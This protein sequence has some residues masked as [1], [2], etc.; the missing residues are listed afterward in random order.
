MIMTR[1]LKKIKRVNCISAF[2]ILLLSSC[3]KDT[4]DLDKTKSST[5][6]P[7]IAAPLINTSLRT[8]EVLN[9]LN[10]T[11]LNI[12]PQTGEVTIEY[13]DE[14]FNIGADEL[15]DIPD[16][17]ETVNYTLTVDDAA[18]LQSLDSI[19]LPPLTE[20]INIDVSNGIEINTL[21]LDSGFLN[22]NLSTDLQ[23]RG[24]IQIS[25]PELTDGNGLPFSEII[26][27]SYSGTPIN[28]V[29]ST[30]LSGYTVDLTNGGTTTN[31]LEIEYTITLKKI[32]GNPTSGN[33]SID[34]SFDLNS[35]VFNQIAGDFS[36][37]AQINPAADSIRIEIFN[38]ILGGEFSLLA[39]SFEFTFNNGF[40]MGI[41]VDIPRLE[42]VNATTGDAT[43]LIDNMLNLPFLIAASPNPGVSFATTK[44]ID[45]SNSNISKIIEATPKW[46][47]YETSVQPDPTSTSSVITRDSELSVD[48]KIS[49]P[50][51]GYG[52]YFEFI[53]T[54]PA[55]GDG[56]AE[57]IEKLKEVLMRF[58]IDNGFPFNIRVQTYTADSIYNL[59][60]SLFSYSNNL[61]ESAQVNGKGTVTQSTRKITDIVCTNSQAENILG[62]KYYII[63]A[64]AETKNSLNSPPENIK[65]FDHYEVKFLMGTKID[66]Q[67]NVE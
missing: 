34:V 19:T 5:W 20:T 38:N 67:L 65:I 57:G 59:T 66:G 64:E 55:S 22:I 63:K 33:E 8:D 53:D 14:L 25:I 6:E 42:S 24:N 46:L 15:V 23:H 7:S 45:S 21:V 43:P 52:R 30:D 36:Q 18:L 10:F 37:M 56:N 54:F 28:V 61:F 4:F 26:S 50:L 41:E 32:D 29:S 39:P 49:L 35:L 16:V 51:Y 2:A 40:G 1:F 60:D 9:R 48:S 44:L 11:V 17:G 12:D 62:A 47:I 58:D 3:V 27:F 31:E 13:E